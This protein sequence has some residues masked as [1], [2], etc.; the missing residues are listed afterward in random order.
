MQI[1]FHN[2]RT[3][4]IHRPVIALIPVNRRSVFQN[5]PLETVKP[6]AAAA[7]QFLCPQMHRTKITGAACGAV[8]HPICGDFLLADSIAF[9]P[10]FL[11]NKRREVALDKLNAIFIEI[12]YA[13]LVNVIGGLG[14]VVAYVPHIGGVA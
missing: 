6:T 3:R 11:R 9:V 13:N 5:A 7:T 2:K 12:L 14:L 4:N 10:Q 1:V 8:R